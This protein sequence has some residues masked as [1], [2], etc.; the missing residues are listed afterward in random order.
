MDAFDTRD[1]SYLRAVTAK[2]RVL[3]CDVNARL[4]AEAAAFRAGRLTAA[5]SF[6]IK[7]GEGLRSAEIVLA[8]SVFLATCLLRQKQETPN[9]PS[10]FSTYTRVVLSRD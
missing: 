3:P 8:R 2:R 4:T 5:K 6:L 1:L 10:T 7:S 9:P